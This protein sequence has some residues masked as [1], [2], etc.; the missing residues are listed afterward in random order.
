[1]ISLTEGYPLVSQEEALALFLE[2][3]VWNNHA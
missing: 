2:L 3:L 1:M